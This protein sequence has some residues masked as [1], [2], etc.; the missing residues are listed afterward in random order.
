MKQ[1]KTESKRILDL[2]I[3]SIYTNKEVFLR[4]LIS[5]ASDA[6]DKRYYQSLTE[7]KESLNPSDLKIQLFPNKEERTLII[8]DQGL[9]M[10]VDE[11]DKDLG[12][13]AKSGSLD[14]K[15]EIEEPNDHIDIIG[16]FGVGFY[17]AFIVSQDV[18]VI[19]KKVGEE[20]AHVW[21]ST[22]ENGYSIKESSLDH[23]GTKIIL[24]LKDNTEEENIRTSC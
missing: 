20:V 7:K 4:E 16:Q 23:F 24:K 21:H 5:N 17:S 13:I 10:S 9:G 1:F 2:M 14:F 11:L 22:G 3:H 12:T 6:M 8:E 19:S 18:Q 15:K